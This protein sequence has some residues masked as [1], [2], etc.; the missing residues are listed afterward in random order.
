MKKLA[1]FPAIFLCCLHV[2][3]PSVTDAQQRPLRLAVAGLSHGHAPMILG[4]KDRGDVRVVGIYEPNREV[5]ERYANRY[6][7]PPTIFFTDL[8]K[9]LNEVKPEAVA[10]FGT[11]FDHLAVVQACAPRGI[12]VM[13]EKPLA[14]NLQHALQ[15]EALSKKHRI[16]VLTNYETT[17][18]ASN[19]AVY[20]MAHKEKMLG[21]LRKIVVHDGHPG[22]QEIKVP[23]EFLKWLIDP[24]L[25]GGGALMDFGCYGAN[26]TTWL[27]EGAEPLTVTAVTQQFKPEIYPKVED[28]ATIVL[29]YC[30]A[31][32]IIQASWNWPTN[33]KDMEVYGR[34]GYAHA[35]DGRNVRL[36]KLGE[37]QDIPLALERR[38]APFDEPFA[39]FAAVVRGDIQIGQADL[40]SLANNMTVMRIL[41]AATRSAKTGKTV[42]L[43]TDRCAGQDGRGTSIK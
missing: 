31:Q 24:V 13:V 3:A 8:G 21:P 26:L 12:H 14:A 34:D 20:D 39:Y 27:M 29:G 35:L 30:K 16:H 40:S 33:R 1:Y 2:T 38:P 37:Q 41:D 15:I 7:L 10:A 23:A 43:A 6:G 28:E 4:R 42:K 36:R 32:A 25:N 9:M 22:P 18:Y 11:T 5:A 19:Q 17:W